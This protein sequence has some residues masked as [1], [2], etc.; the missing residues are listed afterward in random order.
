VAKLKEAP[1]KPASTAAGAAQSFS[2]VSSSVAAVVRTA[3]GRCKHVARALWR[4]HR[5]LV[6]SAGE[7]ACGAHRGAE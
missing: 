4:A 5:A 6:R 7:H 2:F 3:H 1:A